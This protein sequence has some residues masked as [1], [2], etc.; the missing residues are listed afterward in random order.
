MNYQSNNLSEKKRSEELLLPL[1]TAQWGIWFAQEINQKANPKVYKVTECLEIFGPVR[2]DL[3]ETAARQTIGETESCHLVFERTPDGPRQRLISLPFWPFPVLDMSGE[4]DP[5]AAAREWMTSDMERPFDLQQGP[6]FSLALLRVAPERFLFYLSGHHIMMDG[7]GGVL[8][9]SRLAQIYSALIAGETPPA[10]PFSRLS[11][12]MLADQNYEASKQFQRDRQYWGDLMENRPEPL[13]LAGKEMACADVLRRQVYLPDATNQSLRQFAVTCGTTLP[14]LLTALIA[15]YFYRVTGEEDLVLGFPVMA[16][17]SR[18]LRAFPGMMTNVLPLRL[19]LNPDI[20]LRE[21][22]EQVKRQ[23]TAVVRHQRYRGET[24][25]S[26]LNLSTE[27]GTLYSTSIN[28]MPFEYDIRF[29]A[30]PVAVHNLCLGPTDDLSV[31]IYD[32][33][34]ENGL[35]LCIDAN[36]ALYDEACIESHFRRL[37]HFFSIASSQNPD[38]PV[39]QYD[40][41]LP[42]ERTQ[43]LAQW[44][45]TQVPYPAEFCAHELFEHYAASAPDSLA[46]VCHHHRMTYGE[47]N[48]QANQLARYLRKLGVGPEKRVALCFDRGSGLIVAML[49]TLKAG[50][51]YVPLDPNYPQERIQYILEDSTPDALLTDGILSG[52]VWAGVFPDEDMGRSKMHHINF[53]TDAYLWV[54]YSEENLPR[55]NLTPDNLAYIIYTSGSTGKPK[56]VMVEHKTLTNLI[57]WHRQSFDLQTGDCSSSVAGMGFD[58]AVWEIWPPLCAG[59]YLVLPPLAVSRDPEQLLNWWVNQPIQVGFLS[60]PI[61]ELAFARRIK[62]PTLRTLLVGGDRLN[63]L[64]EPDA[65]FT[66]VNN[67]GPTETTVVATSGA[68]CADDSVLHIGRPL[69]NMKIYI[70]DEQRQLVP[71]GVE[72]EIYIGGT[73]VSRGYLNRPDLTAERFLADPFSEVQGARMYRSGDLARWLPDGTIEYLGRNDS[74][75]KIRGFRIEPGEVAS[76]LQ[77]CDCVKNAVVVAISG[78]SLQGQSLQGQAPLTKGQTLEG[79]APLKGQALQGQSSTEKRLVAYYTLYDGYET[80]SAANLKQQLSQV[81]PEYMVPA[82]YVR[83]A[84]IPLTANG[85]VNYRTLPQPD[86]SSFVR[87]AYEAP[88]TPAEKVL[89][90]VWQSLLGVEKAGRMDNFFELGGHSLLA[91]QMSELLRKQGYQLTVKTLF[92]QPVLAELAA[93]IAAE[94]PPAEDIPPSLIP[95]DCHQITPDMLPLVSLTQAQIDMLVSEI[96]GG[97]ANVQDIYPAG[98]LQQGLLVQ[99]L[100]QKQGDLY[101]IR[102]IQAFPDQQ[103]L[104]SFTDALQKVIRRHDILRTSMAWEGLDQPVQIVWRNAPLDVVTLN[105]GA[106]DVADE[107]ERRFRPEHSR[108]NVSHAPMIEAYQA[109]DAANERWLLCLRMHHLCT[110]H[111]S[112]ELMIEEVQA[113]WQGKAEQLP[114]PL[115]FRNYIG[116]VSQQDEQAARAYFSRQLGDFSMPSVPFGLAHTQG[117]GGQVNTLHLAVNDRLAQRLRRQAKLHQVST[118]SLFHLVWGLVLRSASGRDDVVTGTILLGRMSAGAGSD[119]TLGLFLNTLPFRMRLDKTPTDEMVRT[120][121]H[122]LAEL[123]DYEHT[124][125]SQVQQCSGVPAS[126]PLFSSLLNYRYQ[127]GNAQVD[128]LEHLPVDIV[129]EE[130]RSTF[131][132]SLSVNDCPGE[133]FS[134]DLQVDARVSCGLVGTMVTGTLARLVSVLERSPS[135]PVCDVDAFDE[136]GSPTTI[137]HS[138]VDFRA[139]PAPGND[140]YIRCDYTPPQGQTEQTLARLWESVL[141]VDSVGRE[142]DFFA[143]GGHSMM[144]IQLVNQ[145]RQHGID[146]SL[147]MLFDAPVLKDF[148]AAVAIRHACYGAKVTQEQPD[149]MPV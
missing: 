126:Q 74:Q 1:S 26:D 73:G 109:E 37:V 27:S 6:L 4:D 57:H 36:T 86:E 50:A 146:F 102:M 33:G 118:A 40:W 66:L 79:Q 81:L 133:G 55:G 51:G 77:R 53:R 11:D 82:A 18:M 112:L 83:L 64:P 93:L 122:Q 10:C 111:T 24:L 116:K 96:P 3:F 132:L 61:A 124:P 35:E 128:V 125:L 140:D 47:L 148:S 80:V 42:E 84:H 43:I 54:D 101:T 12:V 110:D 48:A 142:D 99:H 138:G 15:L 91:V 65:G 60:T 105:L 127:G 75:V 49:A 31:N 130:E 69:N 95:Q 28:I 90:D 143:L 131:P 68:I 144:A 119:R 129:M 25:R 38:L 45:N 72:G 136:E 121:H 149:E 8:F 13:S 94:K 14:Q 44:N 16:R 98:P 106:E 17:N 115:P 59:A 135:R 107:L 139:L 145:A 89:A 46:V 71:V 123:M 5:D 114:E 34:A 19:S 41:L 134:L 85:K 63:V 137:M 103:M 56:G 20:R 2:T 78:Q 147:K 117:E 87:Q 32:R 67:Y 22:L 100:L 23:V 104:L 113:H 9:S 92:E 21:C 52:E 88:R 62:H 141:A 30:Y 7:F 76:A 58:A 108:I 97:A 29:G 120:I 70:L 39:T